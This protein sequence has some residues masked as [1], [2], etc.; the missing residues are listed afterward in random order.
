MR[1]EE[2]VERVTRALM[3]HPI[4]DP[5]AA[6]LAY[7]DVLVCL[8]LLKFDDDRRVPRTPSPEEV[9]AGLVIYTREVRH[10]A[11]P[12]PSDGWLIGPAGAKRIIEKL[13]EHG[14]VINRAP[15]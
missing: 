15:F 13:A 8:G 7:V 14:W 2:A 4:V 9:L 1:R 5:Q 6:A 12:P 11:E 10:H 3:P